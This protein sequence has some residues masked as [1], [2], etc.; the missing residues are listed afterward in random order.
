MWINLTGNAF[1][2]AVYSDRYA[3]I[4]D[5]ARCAFINGIIGNDT[6]TAKMR[7]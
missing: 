1:A 4:W 5:I 6:N 2:K 3:N 7:R